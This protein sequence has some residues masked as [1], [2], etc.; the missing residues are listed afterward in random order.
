MNLESRQTNKTM[1]SMEC[2]QTTSN[3]VN[4]QTTQANE[5]TLCNNMNMNNI[6]VTAMLSCFHGKTIRTK[7]ML[8]TECWQTN[9]MFR[10]RTCKT[11]DDAAHHSEGCRTIDDLPLSHDHFHMQLA[12][13]V[14]NLHSPSFEEGLTK[15]IA[16]AQL[17]GPQQV[18]KALRLWF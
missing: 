3:V 5:P 11:N 4:G 13:I 7:P 2:W 1:S 14:A 15:D 12:K 9:K 17:P 16:W 8:S 6:H 10:A 18:T